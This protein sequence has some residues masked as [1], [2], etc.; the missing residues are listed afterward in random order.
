MPTMTA[1]LVGGHASVENLPRK[2][3]IQTHRPW[4]HTL[5]TARTCWIGGEPAFE[6]AAMED[7]CPVTWKCSQS[8]AISEVSQTD[9]AKT[10]LLWLL[11]RYWTFV[12]HVRAFCHT[13]AI[14]KNQVK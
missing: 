11:D 5:P 7:M 12:W 9:G 2:V 13:P 1:R 3:S 14:P 10:K 4:S 8:F 6:A